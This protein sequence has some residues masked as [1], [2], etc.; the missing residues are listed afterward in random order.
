MSFGA[1]LLGAFTAVAVLVLAQG[2]LSWWVAEKAEL[3]V[4]RGRVAGDLQSGFLTLSAT[5]QR[6]RAWSLRALIGAEHERND[7]EA[8]RS[9]MADTITR[10]QGLSREANRLTG[11]A[12]GNTDDA[13][14]DDALRLLAASVVALKPAIETIN[15]RGSSADVLTAWAALEAVFDRGAGR[16]LR[17]VLNES[18]RTETELLASRRA[19]A[20]R[21]LA[22]L[23]LQSLLM[24]L[25]LSLCALGLAGYFARALR[26]PLSEMMRG[27]L[28]FQQGDLR[29]RIPVS[30]RD[31]FASF[32]G[33][34]NR[35]A[36]ELSERREQEAKIRAELESLVADRTIELE[37]ALD[38]LRQSEHRRRQLLGDIS[39]E[40]RT[41]TTAI[42]GEAEIA[43]RGSKTEADYR[44]ALAR[45]G[46]AAQQLAALID[47]LI[48]MARSDG[49]TLALDL[50][51]R[52]V[53][54]CLEEA[55][56]NVTATAAQRD[57]G[58]AVTTADD[59]AA[60]RHDPVRIQQIITLLLDNAIRYSHPGSTVTVASAVLREGAKAP[61]WQ[62]VIADE[63]IGIAP[64]DVQMVFERTYR[65]SNARSHRPE[66]T[67]L[68]LA[69]ARALAQR[70][71]GQ[72]AL[73][74]ELGRGTTVSLRF[75]LE[76]SGRHA[77]HDEGQR[78]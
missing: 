31:E 44:G 28:A 45:V 7:G 53:R 13:R 34:I 3:Q 18:I 70:Q 72:I 40:L 27:A 16:D 75:P 8:L 78:A 25:L 54:M 41:P 29:H 74:S 42:R 67:G 2:G 12:R 20:D 68:G 66:G 49:E 73:A 43:L 36:A 15:Q 26:R 38:G 57:I 33:S 30:G 23:K 37:A 55:L 39:H 5:K 62:L 58:L 48:M 77:P 19:D 51:V 63:G 61:V 47:D 17:E 10:L 64:E 1:R 50:Q 59:P 76:A 6:L 24:T 56:V 71:G 9:S 4:V 46:Q 52:D 21:A 14:R 35:M 60:F 65:A 22:A 69:I 11:A 32:A